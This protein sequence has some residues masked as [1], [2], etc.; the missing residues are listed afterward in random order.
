MIGTDAE[1]IRCVVCEF[2]PGFH[3]VEESR[4]GQERLAR[5]YRWLRTLIGEQWMWFCPKCR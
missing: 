5:R 4:E 3:H 1:F 2:A